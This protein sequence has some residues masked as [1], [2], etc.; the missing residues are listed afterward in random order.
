MTPYTSFA[1]SSK[2]RPVFCCDMDAVADCDS[3]G[4][5]VWDIISFTATTTPELED[6]VLRGL[7]NTDEFPAFT[8]CKEGLGETAR[9]TA[10]RIPPSTA[11][12][13]RFVRCQS[14]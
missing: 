13:G 7:L 10:G 3:A 6:S 12:L 9:E 11:A 5:D 4:P 14:W 2:G 8:S 1:S